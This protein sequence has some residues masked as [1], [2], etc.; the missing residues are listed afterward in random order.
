[1]MEYGDYVI[2]G[3]LCIK[4]K[5]PTR[6]NYHTDTHFIVFDIWSAKQNCFMNY[7]QVYQRCHHFD[8]PI[9]DLLGT[10]N[11][12]SMESL[13]AFRDQMLEHCKEINKEGT[14][15]KTWGS[16][17]EDGYLFFKEKNDTPKIEKLP[18]LVEDG[19]IELPILPESEIYGAINKVHVDIGDDIHNIKVAMP[20]VA[21]YVREEC[22]KHGCRLDNKKLI[23]YYKEYLEDFA[24]IVD[25]SP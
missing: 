4:G 1:M 14:V 6:I 11:V 5:S 18:R 22:C 24:P 21:E 17:N 19:T 12:T 9:V 2:F 23:T 15:G 20:K 16:L 8:L 3:E 7:T 13:M 25:S 10:C